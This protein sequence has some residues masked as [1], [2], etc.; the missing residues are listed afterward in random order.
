[1]ALLEPARLHLLDVMLE[2]VAHQIDR[3]IDAF[4][5]FFRFDQAM[6]QVKRHIDDAHL[7][8][9][10]QRHVSL[11]NPIVMARKAVE[12]LLDVLAQ[13]I[14][15]SQIP[16]SDIDFHGRR[17]PRIRCPLRIPVSENEV[18]PAQPARMREKQARRRRAR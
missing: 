15:D 9:G 16:A 13:L 18:L 11:K 6:R 1:M 3:L 8:L 17:R 14:R 12:L 5:A 10:A 7:A 2:P 4:T